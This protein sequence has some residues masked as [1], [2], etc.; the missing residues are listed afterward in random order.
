[1]SEDAKPDE[2]AD[3]RAH[4]GRLEQHM[5]AVQ[6][7]TDLAVETALGAIETIK[8]AQRALEHAHAQQAEMLAAQRKLT[9]M[10]ESNAQHALAWVE[11]ERKA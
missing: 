8:H 3:L 11:M 10:V 1:M 9:A 6:R 2:L 5:L 4:V 7:K